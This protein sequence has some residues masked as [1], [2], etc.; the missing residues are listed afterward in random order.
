MAVMN[1]GLSFNKSWQLPK[2]EIYQLYPKKNDFCICVPIINEGDKIRKQL[3][4]M[5]PYS[6]TADIII[7]D[8]G[9]TDGSTNKSFL[10]KQNVRALVVKTGPGK[11]GTQLRAGFAYAIKNGY[12]GI[13]QVDGNNKDGVEAIPDFI[14]A[15]EE[16]YD[17]IQGSRFIKG[18][19]A[20]N[21]PLS[22]WLGVRLIASPL[23]SIAS[24]YW[25]TDV[26]NGFRG[27]SKKYLTHPKVQ[28]FRNIFNKYEFNI[29]LTARA[30][31]LGLKTKEIPVTRKYAPGKVVTK[32][33]PIKG[34]LDFFFT[35]FKVAVGMYHP[36]E[37]ND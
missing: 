34:N 11:Q 27:Y 20:I 5:K 22:R 7:C 29:Y 6:N 25:Y 35:F 19:K 4:R 37:I 13:I 9:S 23:S 28:P 16:G 17:Y 30:H 21:T 14:K 8:G 2:F 15:L 33:S 31:Q 10:R 24:G 26:T 1:K 32:I 3:E 36:R 18:G 12:K